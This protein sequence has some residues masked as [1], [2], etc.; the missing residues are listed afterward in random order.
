MEK[1]SAV[2][3]ALEASIFLGVQEGTVR[4]LARKGDIPAYMVA[5]DS[6]VR[7]EELPHWVPEK[8]LC[9]QSP[10]ALVVNDEEG[11]CN[12]TGRFIEKGRGPVMCPAGA[13]RYIRP[14]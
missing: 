1:N 8:H 4:R 14:V 11:F 7:W 13:G 5:K 9:G 6:R 12:L 2:E 10:C 3:N